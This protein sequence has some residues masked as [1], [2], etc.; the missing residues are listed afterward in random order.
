[1]D[2]KKFIK[3]RL[4]GIEPREKPTPEWWDDWVKMMNELNYS[5][6]EESI[7]FMPWDYRPFMVLLYRKIQE[8]K[9]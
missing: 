1:M 7:H 3:Q 5:I 4:L 6:D 2:I 9:K 8:M